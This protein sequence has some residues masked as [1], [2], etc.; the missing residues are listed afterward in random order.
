MDKKEPDLDAGG[1][2]K[3][4]KSDSRLELSSFLDISQ[5][6]QEEYE[7]L[8]PRKSDTRNIQIFKKKM[9]ETVIKPLSLKDH[10]DKINKYENL[11]Q[12]RLK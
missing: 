6:M 2:H 12:A 1:S 10:R 8:H 3:R 11:H 5:V 7:M 9:L 4:N